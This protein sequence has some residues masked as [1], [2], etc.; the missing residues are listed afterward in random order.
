MLAHT[1]RCALVETAR[2]LNRTGLNQGTSGNI[3]LRVGDGFFITP[4]ALAYDRYRPADIVELDMQGRVVAGTRKPSSEWRLHRDI[5]AHRCQAGAV[6]H[7]HPPWCTTLAC[8]ELSI[9]P[10][11]YMVAIGGG[12]SIACAPYALFGTAEL[13][14]NVLAALGNDRSACLLAHH[15]MVCFSSDLKSVV[16]LALEVENLARVYVQAL[17]AGEVPLLTQSEMDQV[18]QQFAVYRNVEQ[19]N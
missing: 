10:Y 1:K 7:V 19:G 3:S 2:S 5:Y 17:Q 13:S 4:S 16:A 12:D 11:H 18:R 6:L 9:P 15:G 14:A 8:L